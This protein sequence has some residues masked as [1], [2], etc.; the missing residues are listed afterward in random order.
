M[1]IKD[2]AK[3]KDTWLRGPFILVFC[4]IFYFLYGLIWL[5]VIFQFI[6]KVITGGLN[7]N[8]EQFSKRLSSYVL[9]ILDYIT[10]QSEE[11]PFPFSSFPEVKPKPKIGTEAPTVIMKSQ[12]KTSRKTKTRTRKKAA[13]KKDSG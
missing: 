5:L 9:Q 11:R 10:Y 4:V 12:A 7:D 3:N 2:N 1:N 13:D 6:T 8:L